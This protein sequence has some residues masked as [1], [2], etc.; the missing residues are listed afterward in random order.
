MAQAVRGQPGGGGH[1]IQ[2]RLITIQQLAERIANGLEGAGLF[3]GGDR[4]TDLERQ[5]HQT[6]GP[7]GGQL[8]PEPLEP[9]GIQRQHHAALAAGLILLATL[10]VLGVPLHLRHP[11]LAIDHLES[12]QFS[13]P[14][15]VNRDEP[16]GQ[17]NIM[18][19]VSFQPLDQRYQRLGLKR[20]CQASITAISSADQLL[21]DLAS[22]RGPLR[23]QPLVLDAVL[24]ELGDL[25]KRLAAA[26]T[27]GL[28]FAQVLALESSHQLAAILRAGARFDR[29]QQ[30]LETGAGGLLRAGAQI[31]ASLYIS[32]DR[33]GP[34][35]LALGVGG[36]DLD[37]A[38]GF[39]QADLLLPHALDM[40]ANGDQQIALVAV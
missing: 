2:P 7:L 3:S 6:A 29:E 30:F 34:I 18:A 40:G 32:I 38:V 36:G 28:E 24:Q 26:L 35:E 21:A 25:L 13:G 9:R 11:E 8:S 27:A 37:P 16:N 5:F 14:E 22:H 20:W 1:Q 10:H 12:R 31:P 39:P 19:A 15:P 23:I 17:A 4:C 33:R